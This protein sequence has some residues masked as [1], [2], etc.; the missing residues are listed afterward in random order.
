VTTHN[1][2]ETIFDRISEDLESLG[3]MMDKLPQK[4][5]PFDWPKDIRTVGVPRGILSGP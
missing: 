4:T 2:E 5:N 1:L 3:A